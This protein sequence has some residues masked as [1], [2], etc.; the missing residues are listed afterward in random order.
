[1]TNVAVEPD[2]RL[3]EQSPE[4]QEL[5]GEKLGEMMEAKNRRVRAKLT[6]KGKVGGKVARVGKSFANKYRSKGG[7]GGAAAASEEGA[8]EGGDEGAASGGSEET[9]RRLQG[10]PGGPGGPGRQG[11]GK[12][13]GDSGMSDLSSPLND[14]AT[15]DGDFLSQR[16]PGQ[17]KKS[18]KR[19]GK[20]R[21]RG[22]G[23]EGP[24][25]SSHWDEERTGRRLQVRPPAAVD[26][27]VVCY[28]SY[29]A[30]T[31]PA[32]YPTPTPAYMQEDGEAPARPVKRVSP[33]RRTS[34]S[35]FSR[36]SAASSASS[37]G[38]DAPERSVRPPLKRATRVAATGGDLGEAPEAPARRSSVPVSRAAKANTVFENGGEAPVKGS[39]AQSKGSARAPKDLGEAPEK[40][41][42][43]GAA[44]AD[45]HKP[46]RGAWVMRQLGR[47]SAVD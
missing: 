16:E 5:V 35:S 47:G 38:G 10:G 12:R 27:R 39:A 6:G 25:S 34:S 14:E 15:G 44:A 23:P 4:A 8:G 32:P 1:M 2:K 33:V 43:D 45:L 22:V 20:G 24:W 18:K 46:V 28:P 36:S 26:A 40:G 11:R 9:R 7:K 17:G 13:R 3:S 21:P 41:A 37:E 30:P 19:R 29:S 42:S 31:H